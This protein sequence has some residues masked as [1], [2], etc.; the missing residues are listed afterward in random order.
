MDNKGKLLAYFVFFMCFFDHI[1]NTAIQT[2]EDSG[3]SCKY[4]KLV[5]GEFS[6][7]RFLHSI[8]S[9]SR[10]SC[11]TSVGEEH[12]CDTVGAMLKILKKRNKIQYDR[13]FLMY[14]HHKNDLIKLTSYTGSTSATEEAPD[15]SHGNC[16]KHVIRKQHTHTRARARA[17]Y[18]YNVDI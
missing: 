11:I 17:V 16:Q 6:F 7:S 9:S 18:A 14:P 10:H 3:G 4:E 2:L 15:E 13:P 12:E 8:S 1:E 5:E